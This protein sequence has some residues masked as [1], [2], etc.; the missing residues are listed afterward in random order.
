MLWAP[1]ILTH[2]VTSTSHRL[3]N[4]HNYYVIII[5]NLLSK[6]LHNNITCRASCTLNS[7][8]ECTPRTRFKQTQSYF[9]TDFLVFRNPDETLFHVCDIIHHASLNF[10]KTPKIYI[11]GYFN[12]L[13]NAL[14]FL[15]CR[16][17]DVLC[18]TYVFT[19]KGSPS[20]YSSL[21]SSGSSLTKSSSLSTILKIFHH[22]QNKKVK[23]ENSN[24]VN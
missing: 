11:L 13:R 15:L 4:Y 2:F 7:K 19:A 9:L 6:N 1:S 10:C 18:M 21:L 16:P 22:H 24:D 5:M 14:N 23:E 17:D 8:Q 12:F 20:M 3:I